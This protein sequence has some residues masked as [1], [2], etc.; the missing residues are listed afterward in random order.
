MTDENFDPH[1][2]HSTLSIVAWSAVGILMLNVSYF[3][4]EEVGA[5]WYRSSGDLLA[6]F[7][8]FW[9]GIVK[10]MPTILIALAVWEFAMLFHRCG[11]GDVFTEL[12]I[13]ALKKGAGSLILAGFWS[14]AVAPSITAWM[15]GELGALDFSNFRELA[16]AVI[17]FGG[18][19][20]GLAIIFASAV[21]L[22]REN[23]EIV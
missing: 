12:N 16:L 9:G 13:E 2:I 23:D 11:D 4:G 10:A 14:G 17:L 7:N 8:G 15:S 20:Y 21:Q 22:K 1:T 18:V 5:I 19:L 3:V 6:I